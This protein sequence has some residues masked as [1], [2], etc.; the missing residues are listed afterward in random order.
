MTES[1]PTAG[2]HQLNLRQLQEEGLESLYLATCAAGLGLV[3]LTY[4]LPWLW[5][6]GVLGTVLLLAPYPLYRLLASRYLAR[7]WLLTAFWLA[8]SIVWIFWLPT[9]AAPC[10]LAL[11]VALAALLI[12]R[13]AGLALAAAVSVVLALGGRANVLAIAPESAAIVGV[14]IWAILA[15]I[16]LALRP[17]DGAL[18]WSWQ[19]Y[20]R[21]RRQVEQARDTQADLK[22]AIKDLAEASVQM[23][24][25]N[26][27]LGAARRAAEEAER[28]KAEFVA[29]VSH[30]LRTPL[31]M[32]IGFSEMMLQAP[33]AYG[34]LPR[35]LRADLA[36]IQRNSE[37]LAELIDDVLDLSQIE[38]RQMALTRERILLREIVEAAVEA[39]RPLFQSKGL[40]LTS[41]VP[42]DIVVS[43]DRTRIREV[44]LNLLSNAGR[45]TECGGVHIQ[46]R[47]EGQ[48]AR[49]SVA[50]TGPG[51]APED[52]DRLFRPFQQVDGSI[53]R[54][55]GGTGLGL[56]ISKHFVELHGGHM[57]LESEP[58]KGT[59]ISFTLPVESP[60]AAD[61]SF[62]RWF[63]P[64]WEYRQRTRPVLAPAPE[65]RPRL[66][67]VE[68]GTMLQRLLRRYL[69]QVEIAPV[70]TLEEAA[71]EL[72]RRPAQA[73]LVNDL[74][75]GVALE[76]IRSA[77]VLPHGT[78]AL[79]CALPG[80]E[81][82]AQD[83]GVDGYLVKPISR[84]AL[85]AALD[86]LGV[87]S[88]TVLIV[89][90]EQ[91]AIQ[92]FWRMLSTSGRSYR[93]LTAP[94]GERAL[95]LL[96]KERP[97]LVLLDLIM[98]GMDGFQLLATR[99][100]EPAWRDVPVIVMSAR[101]PAGQPIIS[102]ALGI[103]RGGGLSVAQVLAYINALGNMLR[104]GTSGCSKS[105]D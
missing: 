60:T 69:G 98:P 28:A 63:N 30:E 25:L 26:Q 80:E 94:T 73:L 92:L 12:D 72:A 20:D 51:I 95:A 44:F 14:L 32:I 83:L 78:P 7:A 91:D 6:V 1:A 82:A 67:V 87:V 85:L 97:D 48:E 84:E 76:R 86:R 99:D 38:A 89:D 24:R 71:A 57:K 8:A 10:L 45:F 53:R 36:V 18:H 43:C 64:D 15:L 55:Y 59:V 58:G 39:I 54:R 9:S 70:G 52:Q 68:R 96:R 4:S 62:L 61:S 3:W 50:D 37:H 79:V 49:I 47:T 81:Q 35:T 13:R 33:S 100:E 102:S 66:V 93:V 27:L 77:N 5:Q 2:T 31:N 22:Q 34:H 105:T 75:V 29:N 21:A 88:G 23:A 11:P 17:L 104:Q 101:D 46:A 65:V 74:A 42:E 19:S 103:T 16:G 90:D 40:S 41:E 56:A